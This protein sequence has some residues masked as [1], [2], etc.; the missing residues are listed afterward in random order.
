MELVF[1]DDDV[2][3]DGVGGAK[4]L[5]RVE[6]PRQHPL[7][8]GLV[9]LQSVRRID[10]VVVVGRSDAQRKLGVLFGIVATT[11]VSGAVA[12]GDFRGAVT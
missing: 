4:P 10:V 6:E 8:L 11:A 12:A 1:D 2:V 7:Q 3:A 5:L 9:I